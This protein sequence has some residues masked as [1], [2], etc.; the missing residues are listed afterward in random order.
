[1]QVL[2][3]CGREGLPPGEGATSETVLVRQPCRSL[4]DGGTVDN[5]A[6]TFGGLRWHRNAALRGSNIGAVAGVGA[7]E[8]GGCAGRGTFCWNVQNGCGAPGVIV[9]MQQCRSL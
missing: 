3:G 6:G 8:D 2:G 4:V 1:M 9:S 7:C 5:R